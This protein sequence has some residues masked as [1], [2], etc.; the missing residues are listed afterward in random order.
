M[1]FKS[2]FLVAAVA[3]SAMSAPV[4]AQTDAVVRAEAVHGRAQVSAEARRAMAAGEVAY[5]ELGPRNDPFTST[6]T[7][8]KVEAE[9]RVALAH[10]AIVSG[11]SMPRDQAFASTKTR[12]EVDAEAREAMRL[13]LI[14]SGEL[15]ARQAS[16]AERKLIRMAAERTRAVGSVTASR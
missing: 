16:D 3:L 11:E 15:P 2:R 10:G 1:M 8:A 7:R 12:A 9:A 5:G 13:Q 14:A 6:R 4:F